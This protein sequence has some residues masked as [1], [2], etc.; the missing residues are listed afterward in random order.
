MIK[1]LKNLILKKDLW[2]ILNSKTIRTNNVEKKGNKHKNKEEHERIR[3]IK[4]NK[5]QKKIQLII[6]EMTLSILN[7]INFSD[8]HFYKILVI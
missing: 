4:K 6:E 2:N 5:K 3:E 7:S 8:N 1:N